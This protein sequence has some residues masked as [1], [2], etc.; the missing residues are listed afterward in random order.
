MKLKSVESTILGV[1]AGTVLLL[2]TGATVAR[3][4]EPCG[5]FG[6]CKALI[7]IN[8]T[9]GDIGFHFLMGR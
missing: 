4:A 9:D 3:A 5:D 6:E 8:A 1:A 7:E 2:G